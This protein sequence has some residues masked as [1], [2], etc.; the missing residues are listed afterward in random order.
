MRRRAPALCLPAE[1]L[2]RAPAGRRAGGSQAHCW[3]AAHAGM[4][5]RDSLTCAAILP[6]LAPQVGVEFTVSSSG[7]IPTPNA[8]SW[9]T[10]TNNQLQ[11]IRP[12][13]AS[14][15]DVRCA[16]TLPNKTNVNDLV[17]YALFTN[18]DTNNIQFFTAPSGNTIP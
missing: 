18:S 6:F 10:L 12:S 1:C 7:G 4:A 16:F 2:H 3:K 15:A 8:G 9:A 5:A 14:P 13:A 17:A 11:G